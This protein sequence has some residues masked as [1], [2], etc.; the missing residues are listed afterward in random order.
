MPLDGRDVGKADSSAS[1]PG[2]EAGRAYTVRASHSMSG[3]ERALADA[4]S[5]W[6]VRWLRSSC[7][8]WARCGW[9]EP[10]RYSAAAAPSTGR[11]A[12]TAAPC[13][14]PDSVTSSLYSAVR[15]VRISGALSAPAL[16]SPASAA[17]RR[18]GGSSSRPSRT[19]ST[20]RSRTNSRI[21]ARSRS[22]VR[23]TYSSWMRRA[24]QTSKCS[25]FASQ[26]EISSGTGT[27]FVASCR[28]SNCS[29]S[30]IA[31]DVLPVPGPPVITRRR[32]G[33]ASKPVAS[34][35]RPACCR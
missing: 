22:L 9:E 8:C 28:L 17:D 16:L 27:G 26:D 10:R 34:S 13:N 11:A 31:R 18:S 6:D 23:P 12:I 14:T 19:G 30:R 33:R 35:A 29:V 32:A 4:A 7:H 5:G 25:L 3:D 20:R 1:S 2:S 24:S 15:E 21:R